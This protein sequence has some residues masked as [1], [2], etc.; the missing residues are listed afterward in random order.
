MPAKPG[1][2]TGGPPALAA[3]RADP[4]GA[5]AVRRIPPVRGGRALVDAP[6]G[7]PGALRG[8]AAPPPQPGGRVRRR[9]HPGRPA[10]A[11][12]L[13]PGCPRVPG[14]RRRSLRAPPQRRSPC[15][16]RPP[17]VSAPIPPLLLS[18]LCWGE[19]LVCEAAAV[20]GTMEH[21][22]SPEAGAQAKMGGPEN[23][24]K[25]KYEPPPWSSMPAGASRVANKE[26]AQPPPWI[27]LQ[28]W[29]GRRMPWPPSW[30][31]LVSFW[32]SM[33]IVALPPA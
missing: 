12:R 30:T 8:A 19:H 2:A 22:S 3:D 32:R 23:L 33:S 28:R 11:C 21:H 25:I 27:S 18:P 26:G 14:P 31:W 15:P 10:A 24:S 17:F 1:R 4:A 29:R 16:G 5:A 6:A 20:R 9:E 13:P 7:L